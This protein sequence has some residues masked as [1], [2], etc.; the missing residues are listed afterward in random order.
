MKHIVIA[1][2]ARVD[3]MVTIEA[4][5]A[6][7]AERVILDK[8][9]CGRHEYAVEACMAFDSKTI[10]TDTF[11]AHALNA[12]TVSVHEINELIEKRND[13][14][15][16]KDENEDAIREIEKKMK[17]LASELKARKAIFAA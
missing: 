15:K 11:I 13:V 5:T 12:E 8:G 3:Y 6:S 16:S 2:I 17:E 1:R 10:K 9:I 7:A 14:I 4:E